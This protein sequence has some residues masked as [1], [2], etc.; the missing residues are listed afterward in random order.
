MSRV[1]CLPVATPLP[2]RVIRPRRL[3]W[4]DLTEAWSYREL[5][6]VLAGRNVK[7]RY[8][9]TVLGAAWAVI[10]P[11]TL[12]VVFGVFFGRL[13]GIPS[14]GVPYPLFA[15]AG[16]VPWN[17]FAH[18]LSAASESV[19]EHRQIITKVYFPRILLPLSPLLSGLVDLAIALVI[20]L[21][22]TFS[23]GYAPTPR[24]LVLPAFVLLGVVT[25]LAM[26]VWL[27]ALNALYRDFRYVVPFLIQVWMFATPIAYPASL[28][29]ERWRALYALNPMTGVIEGFRWALFGAQAMPLPVLAVSTG[30][31]LV[32][33]VGG[34]VFFDRMER[35][36]ADVV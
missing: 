17:Y 24:L 2:V 26:G 18:G 13:A 16:I 3:A 1:E 20:L 8:K 30:A 7:V 6:L 12:M 4:I 33:L 21:G 31:V 29:P 34:V 36:F 10:Q 11:V 23:W 15:L 35:S 5:L 25:A 14:D 22:I 19:V 32:L 27:A 9:Q 28:V